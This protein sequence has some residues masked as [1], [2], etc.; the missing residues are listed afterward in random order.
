[1][2]IYFD[3]WPTTR[4]FTVVA[5]EAIKGGKLFK[6]GNYSGIYGSWPLFRTCLYEAFLYQVCSWK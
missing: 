3:L 1:M 6:G 4:D 2:L 5:V